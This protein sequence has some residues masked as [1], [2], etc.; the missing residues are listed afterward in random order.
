MAIFNMF[1]LWIFV[2]SCT[3]LIHG[4]SSQKIDKT[5]TIVYA[6]S[7]LLR[8]LLKD[9]DKR[10]L[11]QFNTS[12]P[13]NLSIGIRLI[14][15]VELFE[16]E[17]ILESSIYM[18][19]MWTDFRLTW[20]PP[21]YKLIHV[22]HVPVEELWQPDVALYNNADIRV[23]AMNTLALV[24]STGQ[25]YY[26]PRARIRTMCQ[27]DMTRFP[28]DQQQCSIKF[29]SFTYDG[30]RMELSM[31]QENST[32]DMAE[33]QTNNEWEITSTSATIVTKRF[34]CCPEPYQHIRFHLKLKRNTVYYTHVFILPAV[35]LAF[36]VPFQFLLPPDSKERLTIGSALLL[37]IILLISMIQT[38]L[39]EAHPTLPYIVQYYC[40]TMVWIALSLILSIWVINIQNK[41]PSKNKVPGYIRQLF[42][43]TFKSLVC[44][45]DD[46]YYPLENSETLSLRSLEKLST[47]TSN[48]SARNDGDKIERDIEDIMKNVNTILMYNIKRDSH[49]CVKT[50]WYQV[51]L[52]LDRMMC[53][54]FGLI[55]VVYTCVLLL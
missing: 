47:T 30:H 33:Y 37:G 22:I 15:L 18:Q 13:V 31:F 44:V 51:A 48:D 12:V 5:D 39:P 10:I 21:D 23:E 45:T 34:S 43:K 42:L 1:R 55:F 40:V 32:I 16:H 50:E 24:F 54:I 11:P 49:A 20:N 25:V 26:A 6:K 27:I 46:N 14:N 41:G 7:S 2:I 4:L 52:V 8:T 29:G 19:L 28:F 53:F 17:E 3:W 35:I 9:Y 38:F 36:I